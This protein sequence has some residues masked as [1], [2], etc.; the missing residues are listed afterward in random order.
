MTQ[1]FSDLIAQGQPSVAMKRLQSLIASKKNRTWTAH[2]ESIIYKQL[3]ICIS[4]QKPSIIRDTL[5]HFRAICQ[6]PTLH[7]S[8]NNAMMF[9][10]IECEKVASAAKQELTKKIERAPQ[11]SPEERIIQGVSGET[12]TDR[13]ARDILNPHLKLLWDTTRHCLDLLKNNPNF[14]T[15]Y[16]VCDNELILTPTKLESINQNL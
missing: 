1:L 12:V 14:D 13:L 5:A 8:F 15:L 7:A 9:A 16:H 10:L 3:T 6:D 4:L 11:P 2:M